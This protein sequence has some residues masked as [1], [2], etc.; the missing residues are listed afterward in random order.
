[1]REEAHGAIRLGSREGEIVEELTAFMRYRG[2]GHEI[3]IPLPARTFAMDDR[4]LLEQR[5]AKRY[6]ELFGR[7]IPNLGQEVMTWRLSA[8][9]PVA[10]P[11]AL[12]AVPPRGVARPEAMRDIFDPDLMARTPHGIHSRAA[13]QPGMVVEGPAVILEDETSTLVGRTFDA[14]VLESNYLL[15]ESKR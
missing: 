14:T 10:A 3:D 6:A 7:T 12:A 1:M 13:L 8:S 11:Q 4:A 15:L 9:I 2:Q 5:F